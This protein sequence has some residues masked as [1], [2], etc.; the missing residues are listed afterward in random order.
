MCNIVIRSVIGIVT[1]YTG[2][3]GYLPFLRII[4][5]SLAIP[6]CDSSSARP[7]A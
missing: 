5:Y 6:A 3:R 7:R 2:I 1:G 4:I